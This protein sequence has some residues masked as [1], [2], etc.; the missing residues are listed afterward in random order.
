MVDNNLYEIY[1]KKYDMSNKDNINICSVKK[2]HLDDKIVYSN[3][4]IILKFIKKSHVELKIGISMNLKKIK[5]KFGEKE[6]EVTTVK[7]FYL[8]VNQGDIFEIETDLIKK[9]FE[10]YVKV[11]EI[12]KLK[13]IITVNANKNL[14]ENIIF[15]NN[16][17]LTDTQSQFILDMT[18][19]SDDINNNNKLEDNK[20]EDNKL[21][22]NKLEDNK[23]EDNK[24][25]DNKLNDN[26]KL[27]NIENVG[28]VKKYINMTVSEIILTSKLESKPKIKKVIV[29]LS[30]F[31]ESI[32]EYFKLIFESKGLECEIVY[33]LH[34]INCIESIPEQIYLIVYSDQTHLALPSRYIFYQVEQT[35]SIFLTD[36]KLLKRT[37][38]MM[39]KA[40]Q[41]WEYS[42]IT[43]PIYSKYC[44]KKLKWVPMPYY[45]LENV[46]QTNWDSCDY[47]IFFYGHPN[48]RRKNILNKLSK[49]FKVKEGWCYYEDNKIN[50]IKKSKI[51]LNLHFYKDAGLETCRI[52]EILNY[53]KLIISESSPLDIS[54]MELYKDY[55]VF[56]DEINDNFSNIKQ[57]VKTIKYYLVNDNYLDK[58]KNS[59]KIDLNEKINNK[60]LSHINL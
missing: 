17:K 18:D 9:Y 58:I 59:N 32:G 23:L 43:R 16:S 46:P 2:N 21:E 44:E 7:H 37:I 4:K 56:V 47:D 22:D 33:S 50:Y 42:I 36:I 19:L 34:L 48:A 3:Y 28:D 55:V 39:T 24:L 38:Y 45:Y 20:L 54:N 10:I 25:D 35:K 1:S 31:I 52:N 41:V 12:N 8:E 29:V 40:E 14:I 13:K 53:N 6:Y 27:E 60:I 57:L 51:I 15:D 49:Y 11:D 26:N 30:K 5:C